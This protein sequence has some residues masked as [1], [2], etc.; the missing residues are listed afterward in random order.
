MT[1]FT[2]TGWCAMFACLTST[3]CLEAQP[4][5]TTDQAPSSPTS[6]LY[7][8]CFGGHTPVLAAPAINHLS[9]IAWCTISRDELPICCLF[10]PYFPRLGQGKARQAGSSAKWACT[11]PTASVFLSKVLLSVAFCVTIGQGSVVRKKEI[12]NLL[13]HCCV[14][15]LA[16]VC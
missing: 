1:K 8:S 2:W 3:A 13:G 7:A 15:M 4:M 11:K 5:H 12:T 10:P 9:V 14:K 16:S 6:S